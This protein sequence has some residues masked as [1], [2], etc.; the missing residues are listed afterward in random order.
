MRLDWSPGDGNYDIGFWVKNLFD[1]R[2]E[3]AA[4]QLNNS[5]GSHDI[6][7]YGPPRMWGVDLVYRF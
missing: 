3:I 2:Y 7:N 4:T 5:L 6:V 1:R